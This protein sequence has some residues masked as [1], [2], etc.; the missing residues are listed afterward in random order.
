MFS[1][2][3]RNE[4]CDEY[5]EVARFPFDDRSVPA[6]YFFHE[7]YLPSVSHYSTRCSLCH[8]VHKNGR[9]AL[10]TS[11][12]K[13][14]EYHPS[15]FSR[16]LLSRSGSFAATAMAVSVVVDSYHE[17]SFDRLLLAKISC[18]HCQVVLWEQPY[19]QQTQP[20]EELFMLHS[21]QTGIRIGLTRDQS[22][23]SVP[24]PQLVSYYPSAILLQWLHTRGL[25]TLQRPF[26]TNVSRILQYS[27][28]SLSCVSHERSHCNAT[29]QAS[30]RRTNRTP[31]A[32]PG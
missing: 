9:F 31:R 6:A 16:S 20:E 11:T 24:C 12:I 10:Q 30:R 18:S 2:R 19:L 22:W 17:P 28:S 1:L 21:T 3:Y 14:G 7:H 13:A 23:V 8:L 15:L 27:V 32:E 26:T 4:L 25:P 5:I 29:T